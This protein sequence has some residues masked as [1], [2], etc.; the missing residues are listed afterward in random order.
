M[1]HDETLFYEEGYTKNLASESYCLP[2]KKIANSIWLRDR[3]VGKNLG[4][5]VMPIVNPAI[6][7]N[8]FKNGYQHNRSPKKTTIVALGKETPWKGL[9]N[10]FEALAIVHKSLPNIELQLFGCSKL[11]PNFNTYG[12]PYVCVGRKVDSELA[13]LYADAHLVVSPSW[14]ESFPLPQLEAMAVGTPVV[15]T[16]F[17]TEDYAIDGENSL[18]VLPKDSKQMSSAILKMLGDVS[19][20]EQC[21]EN[22]LKTAAKFTWENATDAV[23]RILKAT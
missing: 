9:P 11:S 6:D 15:T 16:K 2:L 10:L 22:G 19:L 21:I 4:D 13:Q 1:Q 7:H 20:R 5:A 14:Y 12:V 18:V 3:I 8:I 23:E 17:G